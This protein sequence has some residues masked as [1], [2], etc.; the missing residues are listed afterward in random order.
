MPLRSLKL[1]C[2]VLPPLHE[3]SVF[4]V[5]VLQ[6][7]PMSTPAAA[8][9]GVFTSCLQLQV[10]HL[11]SCACS[12]NS[13]IMVDAP[14][15]EIRELIV[16]KCAFSHMWLRDLPKLESL[17]SLDTMV[18]FEYASFP[19]LRRWNLAQSVGT[20]IRSAE[21]LPLL[22]TGHSHDLGWFFWCTPEITDLAVRFTGP[23][24][25]IMPSSS[26]SLSSPLLPKLRKL[27]VTDVPSS[28]DVSWP[29]L[30]LQ[31]APSLEILHIHIAPCKEKPRDK[32]SWKRSRLRQHCLKEFVVAGFEGTER[33]ICLVRF[34][35]GVSRLRRAALFKK[36]QAHDKGHCD[37]EM[38]T[39]QHSWTDEEKDATL[40]QIMDGV[41]FSNH[42]VQLIL[43]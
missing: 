7:L 12:G 25:W 8:Y 11:K 1:G 17:A 24:R 21:G 4:T 35:I 13:D 43:G 31:T 32:I 2:C 20:M 10:L 39:E 26:S 33:Q 3:F 34:V 36:G 19:C 37:W 5:L 42:P 38:V 22:Y 9:E 40:E 30:L 27:L 28:W 23:L 16:D 14:N 41:S 18:L 15:S 29:R 6:D